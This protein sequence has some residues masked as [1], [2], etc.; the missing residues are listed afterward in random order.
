MEF[1]KNTEY[2]H[3]PHFV[4]TNDSIIYGLNF[5]AQVLA[6]WDEYKYSVFLRNSIKH[7]D[8]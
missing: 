8:V 4:S 2:L 1:R 6:L 3:S 7:L 5:F